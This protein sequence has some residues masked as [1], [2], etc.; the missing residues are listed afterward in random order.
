MAKA[1]AMSKASARALV[2]ALA[3]DRLDEAQRIVEGLALPLGKM[4][5]DLRSSTPMMAAAR[6]GS[7]RCLAWLLEVDELGAKE[8][9]FDGLDALMHAASA[10]DDGS[11]V[12]LLLDFD[13]KRRGSA[14]A[15]GKENGKGKS[16]QG[17]SRASG[18]GRGAPGDAMRERWMH[19]RRDSY[20]ATALDHAAD[21]ESMG[22]FEALL[23][24]VDVNA[25]DAWGQTPLMRAINRGQTEA[26]KKLMPLSDLSLK[27]NAGET[28]LMVAASL[29]DKE[30]VELLLPLSDPTACAEGQSV[31]MRAIKGHDS[32]SR[33]EVIA[34]LAPSADPR[35]RDE[36]GASPLGVAVCWLEDE[37]AD[38]LA[39]L[40]KR[41]DPN[42]P[43]VLGMTPLM[44]AA[45]KGKVRMA[46]AL[47]RVS[48]PAKT[49]PQGRTPFD[50]ARDGSGGPEEAAAV[51]QAIAEGFAWQ[52]SQSLAA[53]LEEGAT[54]AGALA[55]TGA[56]SIA[57]GGQGESK[58]KAS[59]EKTSAERRGGPRL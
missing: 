3:E 32:G 8:V 12:R 11:C 27:M 36:I 28:P 15:A 23:A 5:E 52:E 56:P 21:N 10:P 2:A 13:A 35:Q 40:A 16:G 24:V 6:A 20:G 31:L 46:A 37:E 38:A 41:I 30:M 39:A 22:P 57:E 4:T 54:P 18:A 25:Q 34:L 48:D 59:A 19:E 1:G 51:A 43:D 50:Y 9:D 44:E 45:S 49:D 29:C 42:A 33:A 14:G 17:V 55:R 58:A 7:A 53:A 26:A 47:A